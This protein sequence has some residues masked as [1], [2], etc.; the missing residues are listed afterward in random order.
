MKNTRFTNRHFSIT[1]AVRRTGVKIVRYFT[2]ESKVL[3]LL[4]NN[5]HNLKKAVEEIQDTAAD[6]YFHNTDI[7]NFQ[8]VKSAAI[9]GENIQPIYSLIRNAGTDNTTT[10]LEIEENKRKEN[11]NMKLIGCQFCCPN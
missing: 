3:S 6:A 11:K 9:R 7:N 5:K 4:H 1:V 8:L 10:I 2:G